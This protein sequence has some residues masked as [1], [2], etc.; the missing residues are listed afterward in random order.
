VK[1]A[2]YVCVCVRVTIKEIHIFKQ[3]YRKNAGGN[4]NREERY[5]LDEGEWDVMR[6]SSPENID[7]DDDDEVNVPF[8][9]SFWR[10][11]DRVGCQ[12]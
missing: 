12:R 6:N 1:R 3:T 4:S 10:N 11:V 2:W 5:F 9:P 7:Q 8:P